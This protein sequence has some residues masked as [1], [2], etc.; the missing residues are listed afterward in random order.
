MAPRMTFTSQEPPGSPPRFNVICGAVIY[1]NV[2]VTREEMDGIEV[3]VLTHR[4]DSGQRKIKAS[5]VTKMV[6]VSPGVPV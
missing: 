6:Q 1:A 2:A 3:L 4:K 5:G